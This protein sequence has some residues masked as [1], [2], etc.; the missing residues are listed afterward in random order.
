MAYTIDALDSPIPS[1]NVPKP[2]QEM[3]P[4]KEFVGYDR[5]VAVQAPKQELQQ[6]ATPEAAVPAAKEES[7]TLSPKV[8]AL[9]RKEQAQRQREQALKQ[10]EQDLAQKLQDAEKYHK[11]KASLANKD[12]SSAEEELGISYE[13]YTNHLLSRQQGKNPEE[14]RYTKLEKELSSL[15]KN[16]EE[17]SVKEYQA[18]QSLWKAEI[19]N[20]VKNNEDFSTIRELGAEDIVLQHVND[21]FEEDGI[22]LT[23]EE[24]AKEI[25]AA[26]VERAEKFASVSKIKSKLAEAS[27]PVLGAPKA[28]SPKTITQNMTMTSQAPSRRPFHLLS[29]SEQIAEAY[30][31]VQEAKTSR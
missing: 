4:T 31:R 6:P 17:Q 7:L 15:K 22:E 10:R 1:A 16:Q 25:E 23:A 2:M 20:I 19:S 21:S 5:S 13:E 28:S 24:A 29:E 18:N 11:L 12:Y 3:L 27:K 26:L 8:S 30:R 9:A 14:E